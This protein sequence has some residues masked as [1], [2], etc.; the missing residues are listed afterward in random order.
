[1]RTHS[2]NPLHPCW[3]SN[4]PIVLWFVWLILMQ[5][6][7]PEC[8]AGPVLV[9]I[10]LKTSWSNGFL[11]SPSQSILSPV[12]VILTSILRRTLV[13]TSSKLVMMIVRHNT[14]HNSRSAYRCVR[15]RLGLCNVF[16][17]EGSRENLSLSRGFSLFFHITYMFGASF[18]KRIKWFW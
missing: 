13:Q 1:M 18:K 8:P 16:I 12:L 6:R 7:C 10:H 11:P 17:L 9:W 2:K 5:L 4:N 15:A 3:Q 14:T